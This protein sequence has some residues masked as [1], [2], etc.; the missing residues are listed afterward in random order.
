VSTSD[1]DDPSNSSCS[2]GPITVLTKLFCFKLVC[3]KFLYINWSRNVC[4]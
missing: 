3:F 1:Q 4:L 2:D